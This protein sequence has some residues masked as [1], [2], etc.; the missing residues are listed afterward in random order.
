M[1]YS[2]QGLNNH[3]SSGIIPEYWLNSIY[4]PEIRHA[5]KNGDLYIHDLCALSGY[6]VGW[7]LM[8][9]LKQGFRGV[10]GKVESAPPRHLRSVNLEGSIALKMLPYI[11]ELL[12]EKRLLLPRPTPI[13]SIMM[14]FNASSRVVIPALTDAIASSFNSLHPSFRATRII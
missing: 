2:L 8:D 1:S 6:C 13:Y 5:H 12:F 7:N 4:P 9:L 10:E 11:F 3:I 14:I